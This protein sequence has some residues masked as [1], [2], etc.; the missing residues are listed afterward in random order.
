MWCG[1]WWSTPPANPWQEPTC[2]L[3]WQVDEGENRRGRREKSAR[4]GPDGTFTVYDVHAGPVVELSASQGGLRTAQ[5]SS[6][7]ADAPEPV[8]LRLEGSQSE[9]M[10]GRVLSAEGTPL[11]LAQ[12][13]LRAQERY[14][15]GQVQGDDL[16]EF[17]CGY[18]LFTD[19][20]GKFRT[21]K[22]LLSKGEYAAFAEAEGFQADRT[23]WT[24]ASSGTFP[25]LTLRRPGQARVLEGKARDRG[26]QAIAGAVVWSSQDPSVRVLTDV[27]GRFRLYGLNRSRRVSVRPQARLSLPGP[28]HRG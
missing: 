27:G 4:S 17:E 22:Q 25:D 19:G 10:V 26:G 7:Q 23:P 24:A 13:H 5:T 8:R 12:V 11:S 20:E 28:N 14:P 21:P 1:G 6:S 2:R 3:Y 18:V 15:T 9:S 16:V